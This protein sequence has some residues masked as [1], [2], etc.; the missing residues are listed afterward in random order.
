MN[1]IVIITRIFYEPGGSYLQ[2]MWS[3]MQKPAVTYSPK[4]S[5]RS[6]TQLSRSRSLSLSLSRSLICWGA[7]C[8]PA[9][10]GQITLL[11]ERSCGYCCLYPLHLPSNTYED[12]WREREEQQGPALTRQAREGSRR[13]THWGAV[14]WP[15]CEGHYAQVDGCDCQKLESGQ[16]IERTT[17]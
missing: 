1:C 4:I 2:E 17:T 7:V 10:G 6:I 16:M 13:H 5:L 12:L 15:A 11:M 8:Q 14:T 3:V 9:C